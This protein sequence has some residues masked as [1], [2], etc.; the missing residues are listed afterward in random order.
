[1]TDDGGGAGVVRQ[2]PLTHLHDMAEVYI[3]ILV[4]YREVLAIVLVIL[5]LITTIYDI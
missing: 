4:F 5:G 3:N 2:D 1:M